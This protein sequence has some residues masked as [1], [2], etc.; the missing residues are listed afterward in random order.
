MLIFEIAY[1]V[2]FL[3]FLGTGLAWALAEPDSERE[4][5]FGPLFVAAIA[6]TF[7]M[8]MLWALTQ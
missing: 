1:I 6:L 4:H 8:G 7:A 3:V 2:S 5:V